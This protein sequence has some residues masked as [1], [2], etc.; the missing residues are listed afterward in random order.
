MRIRTMSCLIHEPGDL[1]SNPDFHPQTLKNPS[2]PSKTT[3]NRNLHF[4]SSMLFCQCITMIPRPGL[5]FA[6]AVAVYQVCMFY[7][8]MRRIAIYPLLQ[9]PLWSVYNRS[10]EWLYCFLP[11]CPMHELLVHL[12][13]NA[14]KVQNQGTPPP[15]PWLEFFLQI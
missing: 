2:N 5:P 4:I 1:I 14:A 13:V 10:G 8:S 6:H 15:H 3:S 7:Q 9:L 12:I 11:L